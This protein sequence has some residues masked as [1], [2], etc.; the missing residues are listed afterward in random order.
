MGEQNFWSF[1]ENAF[2]LTFSY[3]ERHE[4]NDIGKASVGALP[5]FFVIV[6]KA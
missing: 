3:L 4:K 2:Q 5:S 1:L 6:V